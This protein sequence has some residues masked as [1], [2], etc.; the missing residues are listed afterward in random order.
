MRRTHALSPAG[1]TIQSSDRRLKNDINEIEYGLDEVL[2]LDPVSYRWKSK[3]DQGRKLGLI[4]QDVQ[5]VIPEVV[6]AP[7][8]PDGMLGMN[9]AELVPILIKAIQEQQRQID[10]LRAQVSGTK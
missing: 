9:Y 2:R 4:A 10:E 6:Y 3:P 5:D 7:D 1:P 8:A